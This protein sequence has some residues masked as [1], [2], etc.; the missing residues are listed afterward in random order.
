M[1]S[2]I[3]A[4]LLL[5]LSILSQAQ[6]FYPVALIP[7]ELLV[8][9]GAVV[10]NDNVKV[11]VKDFTNV[12]YTEKRAITILNNAGDQNAMLDI[13]YDKNRQI[14][15]IKGTVFNEFGIPVGKISEK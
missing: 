4:S 2:F 15:S 1:R 3:V 9:A 10:R 5:T 14:K 13:W 11:E 6:S 7:K 12:A 8:R